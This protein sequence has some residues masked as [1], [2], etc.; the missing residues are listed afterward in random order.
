MRASEMM[1]LALCALLDANKRP[2]AVQVGSQLRVN[3][4]TGKP[5]G[6]SMLFR[7]K[8]SKATTNNQSSQLLLL[9][10]YHDRHFVINGSNS[11]FEPSHLVTY[12]TPSQSDRVTPEQP[13]S[14]HHSQPGAH[15]TRPLNRLTARI[16]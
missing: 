8:S 3:Y 1:W 12:V 9:H 14:Q 15:Q 6:G 13:Q 7:R 11:W 2:V 10:P 5:R 16:V 4:W